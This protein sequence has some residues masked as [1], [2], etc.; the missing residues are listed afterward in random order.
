M[1]PNVEVSP[2]DPA[3]F[4]PR[5]VAYDLVYTPVETRFLRDARARSARVVSGLE[6]FV[7]Q[8]R[9]QLALWLGADAVAPLDDAWLADQAR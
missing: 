8:A 1:H 9:A 4:G 3:A 6:H 5:T 2:A 7:A